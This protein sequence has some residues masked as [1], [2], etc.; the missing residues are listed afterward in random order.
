VEEENPEVILQDENVML[1]TEKVKSIL[2]T[3]KV[4][5]VKPINKNKKWVDD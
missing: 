5:G 3:G 4:F 2:V 1:D